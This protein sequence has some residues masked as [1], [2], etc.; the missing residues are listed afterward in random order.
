MITNSESNG[1][2]SS[3]VSSFPSSQQFHGLERHDLAN[4]NA[5][6]RNTSNMRAAAVVSRH[7]FEFPQF[8]QKS[9]Y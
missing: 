3:I 8:F 7:L 4:A 9:L 6:Q 1:P 5:K 2:Q